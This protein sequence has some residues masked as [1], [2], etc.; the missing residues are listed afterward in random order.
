M[1]ASVPP[2]RIGDVIR[3]FLSG[4]QVPDVAPDVTTVARGIPSRA[5]VASV[6]PAAPH[7]AQPVGG[8]VGALLSAGP[9]GEALLRHPVRSAVEVTGVPAILRG[10]RDQ[11]FGS[12]VQG[13]LTAAPI[14]GALHGV[15]A[16]AETAP[17]VAEA[18]G[19]GMTETQLQNWRRIESFLKG[20]ND[21]NRAVRES[22][23]VRS[24]MRMPSSPL[25]RTGAEDMAIP[26]NV[27]FYSGDR[28][29]HVAGL[30]P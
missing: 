28:A 18:A 17:V 23:A 5:P 29:K 14:F 10:V 16:A 21:M 27:G 8:V 6:G 2:D 11:D 19:G 20:H 25:M 12:L 26:A 9:V 1:G 13:A 7:Y 3:Q 24:V 22:R 30:L 15:G 4:M